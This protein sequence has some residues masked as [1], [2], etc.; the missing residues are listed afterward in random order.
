M[1][2]PPTSEESCLSCFEA[3]CLPSVGAT[4]QRPSAHVGPVAPGVACRFYLPR[5]KSHTV[6]DVPGD[7]VGDL[8]ASAYIVGTWT[9]LGRLEDNALHTQ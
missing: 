6:K 4:F 3:Q 8:D 1:V 7:V 2:A 9:A 5:S